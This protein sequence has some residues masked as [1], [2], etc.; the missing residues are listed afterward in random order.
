MSIFD[1][2]HERA[3]FLLL[4][5]GAGLVLALAPY[6]SGL[7]GALVLYV[8][9]A[10]LYRWF[11]RR[12]QREV[13]AV[14]VMV[15]AL[16][17]IVVPG[18]LLL[19]VLVGQAKDMAASVLHSPLLK[20]ISELSIGS[21]RVGPQLVDAGQQVISWL[22]SNAFSMI[23]TATRVALN[24]LFA[25]F[26]LFYMLQ[27]PDGGWSVVEPYI[28]FSMENSETLRRRFHNVTISTLIGT[29]LTAS[30]QGAIIGLAFW[31]T[32]LSNPLFWGTVTVMVAVLPIVGSGL[33]WG[34]G[35]ASLLLEGH[36]GAAIVL[37]LIGLIVVGNLD[38]VIRPMV[39]RK[40]AQIHPLITLIGAVA[41]V[42]YFGLLGLLL[43][44]LALS[45]FFE[46]IGMYRQEYL[47]PGSKSGMTGEFQVVAKAPAPRR[48][49]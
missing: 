28:P 39:S 3:A 36:T 33:I 8:I 23:G 38:H 42:G 12:V 49:R 40:Y 19:G 16:L 5:L 43:G 17:V 15:V 35:A 34:P 9:F 22:G 45:Y 4:L 47:P 46:L 1:T 2:S 30:I 14:L 27:S 48:H 18:S 29:G 31:M 32:G 25:F 37:A 20:R 24:L 11:S 6:A 21:I 41:G 44:P 26:G 13:A 7:I 10:P